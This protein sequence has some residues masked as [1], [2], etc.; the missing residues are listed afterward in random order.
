MMMSSSV[1]QIHYNIDK[2]TECDANF[3]IIYGEKSNGKSYQA[4]QNKDCYFGVTHYLE[5][6]KKFILLRR[7]SADLTTSWIEKYFSDVDVDKLTDGKYKCITTW[8]KDLYFSNIDDN[9]KVKR[10]E[11]APERCEK[12]AYCRATKKLTKP[13]TLEELDMEY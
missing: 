8:R 10:G 6:G 4:K 5:T 11:I 2:I 12:C 3:N 9:F 13:I 7:W 1:K